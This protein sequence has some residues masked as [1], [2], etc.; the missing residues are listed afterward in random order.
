MLY[1]TDEKVPSRHL[2]YFQCRVLNIIFYDVIWVLLKSRRMQSATTIQW[3]Y[4]IHTFTATSLNSCTLHIFPLPL[5]SFSISSF[6][7]LVFLLNKS[8][9]SSTLRPLSR[10]I[11]K[12]GRK[13]KKEGKE[14]LFFV[15]FSCRKKKKLPWVGIRIEIEIEKLELAAFLRSFPLCLYLS[16]SQKKNTM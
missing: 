12:R 11:G 6:F 5:F 15:L 2:Q 3:S 14:S 16:W 9:T 7:M 13:K 10:I 4:T 1:D 8:W